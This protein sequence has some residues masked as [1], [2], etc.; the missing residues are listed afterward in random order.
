MFHVE[1]SFEREIVPTVP[2]VPRG[3]LVPLEGSGRRGASCRENV[4]R[5]TWEPRR[6]RSLNLPQDH[7]SSMFHVEHLDDSRRWL[8]A[9]GTT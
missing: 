7:V 1:Q 8:L 3:T 2:V 9:A 6:K 5:G 4:P